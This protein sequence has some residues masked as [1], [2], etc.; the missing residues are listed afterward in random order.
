[1]SIDAFLDREY[2]LHKYN[3]GHFVAD[4]WKELT[5]EDI[6]DIFSLTTNA[7]QRTR[8][9]EPVS[10]CVCIMRGIADPHAGVYLDGKVWHLTPQGVQCN[11]LLYLKIIYRLSFYR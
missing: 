1:M 10:P 7:K 5:G 4:V 8:L 3:C 6:T 9:K 2:D 11:D